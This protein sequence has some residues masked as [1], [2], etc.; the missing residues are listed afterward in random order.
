MNT[1]PTTPEDDIIALEQLVTEYTKLGAEVEAIKERQDEIKTLLLTK[2][3]QGTHE[4]GPFKVTVKAGAKRLNNAALMA[5]YPVT[6]HPEM[7]KA[8]LDTT[9]VKK[10]IAPVELEQ[11]QDTGAPTLAVK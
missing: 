2:L 1:T 10:H 8:A 7:Y 11:F 3:P 6:A 4:A 5:A 9:A